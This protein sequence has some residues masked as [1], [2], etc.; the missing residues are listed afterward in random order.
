MEDLRLRLTSPQ[1]GGEERHL[2]RIFFLFLLG[3]VLLAATARAVEPSPAVP[4]FASLASDKVYMR[5][6]PT[7]RHPIL[8]VY[9]RRGLPVEIVAQYDVCRKVRDADGTTGWVHASMIAERRTVVVTA[10]KPAPVRRSDDPRGAIIALA[11][12]GV[13]A[14][15]DACEAT[16]CEIEAGETQGWIDKKN[17]WGVR[18]GEV[19]R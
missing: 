3:S 4:R 17:I 12:K 2:M 15:L 14:K 9:H 1:G 8:W 10:D 7:Y 5:E 19:F 11:G 16:A 13:I 6:G 18:V